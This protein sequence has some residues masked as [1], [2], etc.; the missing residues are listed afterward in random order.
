M[1]DSKSIPAAP[2]EDAQRVLED[3]CFETEDTDEGTAS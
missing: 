1:S 3:F 2:Q